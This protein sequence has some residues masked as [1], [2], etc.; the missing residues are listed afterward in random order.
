MTPIELAT[1]IDGYLDAHGID[2]DRHEYM[3]AGEALALEEE[4]RRQGV[5]GGQG[6]A[7]APIG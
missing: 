6:R 1:A 2:P 4:C 7:G 5:I 3:T